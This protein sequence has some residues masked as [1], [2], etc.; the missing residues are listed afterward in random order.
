[1]REPEF[2]WREAGVRARLLAPAAALYA[3]AARTRLVYPGRR[4]NAPVIC[5]GNLVLGG[6]GKTPTALAMA[7][8]LHAMHEVP[9]FLTRGYGGT[10]RGPIKVDALQHR[11]T[12]VGDEPLL[13][14]Q[15]APT[16]VA[17]N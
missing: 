14:A 3:T 2:W 1:M 4:A 15:A 6:A 12:E 7:N 11:A 17:R 5:I 10:V 13:L 9:A 8:I 16:V